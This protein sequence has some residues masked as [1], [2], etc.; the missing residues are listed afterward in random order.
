[1]AWEE[2]QVAETLQAFQQI[3]GENTEHQKDIEAHVEWLE[4]LEADLQ[5]YNMTLD[6]MDNDKTALVC[7][8]EDMTEDLAWASILEDL[9]ENGC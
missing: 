9:V 8:F 6:C 7:A 1:M 2:A 4:G 3:T 5:T